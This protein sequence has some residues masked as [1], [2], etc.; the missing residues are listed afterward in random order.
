M[1][2]L[3]TLTHLADEVHS[4][5]EAQRKLET[6]LKDKKN[7][8]TAM[9]L[10]LDVKSATSTMGKSY[11]VSV[12]R[13]YDYKAPCYSYLGDKGLL[14]YF[15]AEPKVTKTKLEAALKEGLLSHADM[16]AIEPFII[17]TE[18]YTLRGVVTKEAA[19]V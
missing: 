19:L 12:T 10:E 16:A 5:E 13:K 7:Q 2:D 18:E 9:C 14:S 11:Q 1:E 17:T 4:L 6:T 3:K 15:T 8:L